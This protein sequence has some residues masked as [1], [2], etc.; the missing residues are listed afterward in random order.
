MRCPKSTPIEEKA[1]KSSLFS[2]RMEISPAKSP[3]F[4]FLNIQ[5]LAFLLTANNR[6]MRKRAV[7]ARYFKL[8][9][10]NDDYETAGEDI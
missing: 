5:R 7:R 9:V 4:M 8:G 3:L 6:K 2:F 1:T 10:N